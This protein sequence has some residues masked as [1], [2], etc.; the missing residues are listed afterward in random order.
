MLLFGIRTWI[1]SQCPTKDGRAWWAANYGVTQSRTWLKWL[2]SSSPISSYL[3]VV[4]NFLWALLM[5]QWVKNLP[6][7]Q[8]TQEIWV[9]SLGQE[10]PLEEDMTT[11]SSILAWRIPWTEKPGGLQS[12]AL[13]RVRHDWGTKFTHTSWHVLKK[14]KLK[15]FCSDPRVLKY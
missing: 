12:M 13:Q 8:E 1:L 15:T 5:A 14:K 6:V 3:I 10:D 11:H 2:S 7:M 9:P 4:N